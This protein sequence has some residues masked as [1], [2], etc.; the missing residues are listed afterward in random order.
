MK[1][2]TNVDPKKY[3]EYCSRGQ[4]T[5]KNLHSLTGN[6]FLKEKT[7]IHSQL[8]QRMMTIWR[9]KWTLMSLQLDHM[10]SDFDMD[11]DL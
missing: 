1:Q 3:F 8:K 6:Y 11:K 9:M 10:L 5:L 2:C 7:E 4:L